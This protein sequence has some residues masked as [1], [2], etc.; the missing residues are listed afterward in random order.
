MVE[1]AR[2]RE[3]RE[4]G[5]VILGYEAK[6]SSDLV[7]VTVI[8]PGPAAKH[9]RTRFEPDGEW[10]EAQIASAYEESGRLTTYLG[11]WHTHPGGA[12]SPSRRDQRTARRIA[13][14]HDAR[15]PHP[16]M[17]IVCGRGGAWRASPYRYLRTAGLVPMELQRSRSGRA[18]G[19]L[20]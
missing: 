20:R 9:R 2:R 6:N 18:R 11:D 10:Q 17:L 5:G 1:E 13:R 8:G 3:P 19:L 7:A 15:A 12:P 4:S 14:H 16:L